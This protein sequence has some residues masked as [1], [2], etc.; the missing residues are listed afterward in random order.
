MRKLL[1][2][3][4]TFASLLLSAS[5]HAASQ[6]QGIEQSRAQTPFED[7]PDRRGYTLGYQFGMFSYGENG[8]KDSGSLHGVAYAYDHRTEN[9][10]LAYRV[11]ADAMLGLLTYDGA[12]IHL[13]AK[14]SAPRSTPHSTSTLDY[15][16]NARAL[17]GLAF[18]TSS[19]GEVRPFAG[20]GYRYLNDNMAGEGSYER[21]VTYIYLP[22]GISGAATFNNGWSLRAAV[23]YD[24]LL[25]GLV[26]SHLTQLGRG[27]DPENR[28]GRGDGYRASL[29][30]SGKVNERYDLHVMP[31]YQEWHIQDSDLQYVDTT[32]GSAQEPENRTEIFGLSVSL[33]L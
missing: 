25:S 6:S 13:D 9:S 16:I 33:G 26:K 23:E 20:L 7:A 18:D 15:V 19:T 11:E 8:M 12:L 30:I 32:F 27:S 22:L 17:V 21:E 28:Q 5:A 31:F 14:G 2:G 1:F 24:R 10:V 3:L 4:S 29:D